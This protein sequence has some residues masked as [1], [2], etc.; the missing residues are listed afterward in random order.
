[1]RDIIIMHHVVH[2][3]QPQLEQLK[4]GLRDTGVLRFLSERSYL[5][6]AAFPKLRDCIYTPSMLLGNIEFV[7]ENHER[8]KHA[9]TEYIETLGII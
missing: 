6:D 2:I 4:K 3:G 7:G 9:V 1:M 8:I 5:W